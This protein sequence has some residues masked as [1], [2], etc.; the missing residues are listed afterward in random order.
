M[1]PRAP[2][3]KEEG[4]IAQGAVAVGLFDLL[5]KYVAQLLEARLR[6]A[7]AAG[8][9]RSVEDAKLPTPRFEHI[10]QQRRG[11]R[12]PERVD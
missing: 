5:A 9:P 6:N 12:R 1:F 8:A 11:V 7:R 10:R 4:S 2:D 3:P